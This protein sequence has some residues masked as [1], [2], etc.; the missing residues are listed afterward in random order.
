MAR[1]C[2]P[3]PA[4]SLDLQ[5]HLDLEEVSKGGAGLL[6]QGRIPALSSEG[7]PQRGDLQELKG[8]FCCTGLL[9]DGANCL[10]LELRELL[11]VGCAASCRELPVRAVSVERARISSPL[12]PSPRWAALG[13][14]EAWS[15]RGCHPGSPHAASFEHLRRAMGGVTCTGSLEAPVAVWQGSRCPEAA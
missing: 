4:Q 8:T 10:R 12:P 7:S 13:R 15:R 14:R 2:S 5:L 1:S 6:W 3:L 9:P 11:S